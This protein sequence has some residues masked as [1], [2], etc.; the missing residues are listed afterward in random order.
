M[1]RNLE[2]HVPSRLSGVCLFGEQDLHLPDI[3]CIRRIQTRAILEH[4]H[5][6]HPLRHILFGIIYH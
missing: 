2:V 3:T 5:I 1:L 4:D 6:R